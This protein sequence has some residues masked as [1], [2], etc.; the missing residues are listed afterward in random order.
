[1]WKKM[2]QGCSSNDVKAQKFQ[3]LFL[4]SVKVEMNVK[5]ECQ[6]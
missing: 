2:S 3:D 6:L 5:I 1:M 4:Q